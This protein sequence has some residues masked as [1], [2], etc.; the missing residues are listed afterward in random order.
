MKR[1][2]GSCT[3]GRMPRSRWLR[4]L[5]VSVAVVLSSTCSQP[6][7]PPDIVILL[8]DDLG[9]ADVGYHANADGAVGSA[10]LKTPEIDA[11]ARAGLRLERYRTAPLCTPARAGLLTGRSPLR[12]GL[13]GNI[14][15]A[16]TRSLPLDEELLPAAFTRAGYAT[17]MI[18]K[19]HLGH[20]RAEQWPNARGFESFFGFHGGLI[21]YSSHPR[22]REA[23]LL[24]GTRSVPEAGDSS[25]VVG[26]E[27]AEN[28][29]HRW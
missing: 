19:W 12:L 4:D 2:T 17:A 5:S 27:G 24:R 13:L 28:P 11:L 29:S 1:A 7:R 9:W 21:D 16:D 15:G 22:H 8:A 25:P 23:G 26:D 14:D 18:G 6:A 20:A 10:P 3:A